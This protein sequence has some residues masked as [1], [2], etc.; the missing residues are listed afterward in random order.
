M[1]IRYRERTYG[2]TNIRRW[3]H[4]VMLL[5]MFLRGARLLKFV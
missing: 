4:G 3:K 2:S 5:F 1:P